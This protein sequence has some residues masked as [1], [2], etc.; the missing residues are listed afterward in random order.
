MSHHKH[1]DPLYWWQSE[2]GG[3]APVGHALRQQFKDNW[4][5]FHSLPESKRYAEDE[6][7]YVEILR[8]HQAVGDAI[9]SAGETI[10]IYRSYAYEK[11]LH[12]KKKH[13]LVG[14]LFRE[15]MVRLSINPGLIE[16]NDDDHYY[17]R[18]LVTKWTPDFF[19]PLIRQI[20]DFK[21][22]GVTIASPATRAIFCPY[23]GGIDLFT[24]SQKHTDF[25]AKFSTWLSIR[26]DKL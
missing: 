20:A 14:R 13:Q 3:I 4:A 8:R 7:E 2:I 26:S 5:R 23:D 19:S 12:G 15:S 16:E 6:S 18:A 10:Y 25:E 21:E 1:I 17:V 9:F 24:F 11:K 22:F